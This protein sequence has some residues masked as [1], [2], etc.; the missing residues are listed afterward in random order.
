MGAVSN[1]KP[2]VA[3]YPFTT[4]HPTVAEITLEDFSVFTLADI[5]GLIEGAHVNIGLGHNF[6]QHIERTKILMYVIDISGL[7]GMGIQQMEDGTIKYE[8]SDNTDNYDPSVLVNSEYNS[9][10]SNYNINAE[11]AAKVRKQ[12]KENLMDSIVAD[13]DVD[14]DESI[15]T[16]SGNKLS[17]RRLKKLER[18]KRIYLQKR[19]TTVEDQFSED[20]IK[21]QIDDRLFDERKQMDEKNLQEQEQKKELYRKNRK[22]LLQPWEILQKLE[23][24]LEYYIPGLSDR[25]KLILANKIDLPGAA[26]NLE[27]LRTKTKL[28][29][30]PVSSLNKTN[31]MPVLHYLKKLLLESKRN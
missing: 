9:Y 11:V 6:L 19:I 14:E 1:A 18:K 13:Y 30:F 25:A 28:P 31:L 26:K 22:Q 24:E 5:P 3:A 17:D 20:S 7:E 29:I 12:E 4:L 16:V 8:F 15:Q 10:Q 21:V 27:I 2:K 23:K